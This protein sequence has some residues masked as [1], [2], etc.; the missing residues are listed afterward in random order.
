MLPNL[1]G[2]PLKPFPPFS[3][4]PGAPWWVVILEFLAFIAANGRFVN[5][6]LWTAGFVAL[7]LIAQ[8]NG[9]PLPGLPSYQPATI[10]RSMRGGV[11]TTVHSR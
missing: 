3:P 7:S 1:R 8:C 5:R 10:L 9:F 2:E 11:P 6:I 4:T